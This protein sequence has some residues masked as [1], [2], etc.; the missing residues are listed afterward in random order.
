MG[1][2]SARIM[3]GNIEPLDKCDAGDF[4]ALI[5][6]GGFGAAKNLSDF[7]VNGADLTVDPTLES[8]MTA[9]HESGKPIGVCCIT[10]TIAAKVFRS[11]GVKLTVG[12]DDESDEKYPFAGAAGAI[13]GLGAKH[14]NCE[15]SE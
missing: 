3:R 9:F 6:P 7:A 5:I 14:V 10:P 12:S 11:K 4:D 8:L 2:E 15:P 1:M 13:K